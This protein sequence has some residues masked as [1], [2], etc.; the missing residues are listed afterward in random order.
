MVDIEIFKN[1]VYIKDKLIEFGFTQTE[2]KLIFE[3]NIC[4]GEYIFSMSISKDNVIKLDVYE[5]NTKEPLE[6][7]YLKTA[8]GSFISK[9]NLA[10][11]T[12]INEIIQNCFEKRIFKSHQALLII[13]YIRKK[14]GNELEFLWEKFS[15]NAIWRR[16]DNKKWYALLLLISANK[17]KIA[18]NE[19]IEILDIRCD[20]DEISKTIDNNSIFT[21]YHMNK[22]H[23]ITVLLDNSLPI[24]KIYYLIDKSYEIAGY[25]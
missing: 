17:L 15:D 23:W 3:K 14:Y 8:T 7:F 9:I 4:D 6:L 13:D 20:T 18:S 2:D 16:T 22:K 10:C 19:K 25:K 11:E 5:S 1:Y 21:G 12:I 24:E